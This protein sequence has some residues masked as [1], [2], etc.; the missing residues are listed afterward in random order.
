M[1]HR[2]RSYPVDF[3]RD[4]NFNGD[5]SVASPN[6]DRWRIVIHSGVTPPYPVDGAVFTC[7]PAGFVPPDQYTWLSP[8]QLISGLHYFVRVLHNFPALPDTIRR[9][10]FQLETAERALVAAWDNRLNS[11]TEPYAFVS[12]EAHTFFRDS[13]L[14]PRGGTFQL[15]STSP[16]GY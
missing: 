2:G 14:F 15:S 4:F 1:A 9:G 11:R 10:T 8:Q 6:P 13:G 12:S 16:V 3:R 7:V 5:V